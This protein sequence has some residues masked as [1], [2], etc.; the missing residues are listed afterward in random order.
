MKKFQL[1]IMSVMLL[2]PSV[3]FAQDCDVYHEAITYCAK[4]GCDTSIDDFAQ[5]LVEEQGISENAA[6]GTNEVEELIAC[7]QTQYECK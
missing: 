1:A 7:F 6:D 5:C 3:V 2:V 4:Q